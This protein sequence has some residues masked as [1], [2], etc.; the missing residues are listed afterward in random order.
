MWPIQCILFIICFV[1]IRYVS[2]APSH[3]VSGSHDFIEECR[4]KCQADKCKKPYIDLQSDVACDAPSTWSIWRVSNI[5]FAI[6]CKLSRVYPHHPTLCMA[7]RLMP[8]SYNSWTSLSH[9]WAWYFLQVGTTK[10]FE[11]SSA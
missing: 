3:M 2:M 10:N 6:I 11:F 4:D 7:K 8:N 1:K 5:H 9:Q